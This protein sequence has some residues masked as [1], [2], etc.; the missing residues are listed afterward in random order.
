MVPAAGFEPA[1]LG[2]WVPRSNQL[3]YAGKFS[4]YGVKVPLAQHRTCSGAG[5]STDWA[6]QPRR[7]WSTLR[8][9]LPGRSSLA[10]ML[11]SIVA[12]FKSKCLFHWLRGVDS[13]H[14]SQGYEP[15][16]MPFLYP[17]SSHSVDTARI[18]IVIALRSTYCSSF[19]KI[20]ARI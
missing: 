10:I 13:N 1:T 6:T 16:E 17:A 8:K 12:P 4:W 15:C 18:T 7:N 5:R 19:E 20:R 14:Q 2:L 11:R 9:S 3:S